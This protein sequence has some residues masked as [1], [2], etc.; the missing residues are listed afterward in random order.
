[1][2]SIEARVNATLNKFKQNKK[3]L[4][5]RG[6]AAERFD[7][8]PKTDA[9]ESLFIRDKDKPRKGKLED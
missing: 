4:D 5:R 2:K 8:R 9:G 6:Q 3:D 1:M 7:N